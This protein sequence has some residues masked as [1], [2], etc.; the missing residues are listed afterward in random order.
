MTHPVLTLANWSEF[1][2]FLERQTGQIKQ[3]RDAQNGGYH[4]YPIYR[5]QSDA[6]WRL[7]TTLERLD[8][9]DQRVAR[10]CRVLNSARRYL[11]NF[12]PD[13]WA[14]ATEEKVTYDTLRQ[15]FPDYEFAAYLRH[16]GFPSPLLD[17]SQS[18]Y[19]AAYFAF[20]PRTQR[21]EVA[22]YSLV[23]YAGAAKAFMSSAPHIEIAGP[24]AAIHRRHIMQQCMYSYCFKKDDSNGLQFEQ[25]EAVWETGQAGEAHDQLTKI[26]LP[27]SERITALNDLHRMNVMPHSLFASDDALVD[28]AALR[29]FDRLGEI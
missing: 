15:R 1:K 26:V 16:H 11:G 14:K 8:G 19:V 4:S 3:Q 23:E 28:S 22:I 5:G 24:W 18:P 20:A 6:S 9:A 7:C 10:Y 13:Q 25:H 17:W 27:A 21:N 12:V 29:I 2:A